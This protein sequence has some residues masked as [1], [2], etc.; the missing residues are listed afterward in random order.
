[1]AGA[2]SSLGLWFINPTAIPCAS[3]V[4]ELHFEAYKYNLKATVQMD[5]RSCIPQKGMVALKLALKDFERANE[6]RNTER[7]VTPNTD[8][9]LLGK[10]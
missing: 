9:M 3:Y 2:E 1:M 6:H 7:I 10:T 8:K 5:L 4:A